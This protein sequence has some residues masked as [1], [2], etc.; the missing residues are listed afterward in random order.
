MW[1]GPTGWKTLSWT[2]LISKGLDTL[3]NISI[4]K[5]QNELKSNALILSYR[6][7]ANA[8]FLRARVTS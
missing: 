2:L 3:S 5:Q 4:Q 8:K 7:N 1:A 6:E